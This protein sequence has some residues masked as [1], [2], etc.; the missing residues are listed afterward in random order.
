MILPRLFNDP[1]DEIPVTKE[2]NTRGT[3]ISFR[4]LIKISPPR[5]NKYVPIKKVRYSGSGS[6]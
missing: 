6:K 4:R 5:L 2:K 1:K 3:I